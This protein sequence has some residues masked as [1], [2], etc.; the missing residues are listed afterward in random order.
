MIWDMP[1]HTHSSHLIFIVPWNG[2]TI[3]PDH[4]H[5]DSPSGSAYLPYI[6]HR[7]V[8]RNDLLAAVEAFIQTLPPTNRYIYQ[9]WR[10][11]RPFETKYLRNI[12][13]QK[14]KKSAPRF[15]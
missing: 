1:Y 15:K 14:T 13:R 7:K 3:Q 2:T 10:W 4:P 8:S 6:S 9:P 12:D 11:F 5:N